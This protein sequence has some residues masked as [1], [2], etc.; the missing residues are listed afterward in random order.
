[1]IR[2][3]VLLV[4]AFIFFINL[5]VFASVEDVFDNYANYQIRY[6]R[7]NLEDKNVSYAINQNIYQFISKFKNSYKN[8]EFYNGRI[9]YKV[10]YENDEFLSL[11]FLEVKDWA[12]MI[13]TGGDTYIYKHGFVYN[14]LTGNNVPLS[15][16]VRLTRGDLKSCSKTRRYNCKGQKIDHGRLFTDRIP[17]D[18]YLLGNGEIALIFQYPELGGDWTDYYSLDIAPATLRLS[19]LDIEYFNRKN[20]L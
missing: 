8:G 13:E 16:F 7:I 10:A 19:Q 2:R 20:K 17:S 1:M 18:Y 15:Y 3:T 12:D 14:K 6:P 5:P 9:D 4:V 11:I